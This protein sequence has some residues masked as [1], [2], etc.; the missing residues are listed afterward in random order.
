MDRRSSF[1]AG[2]RAV[3]PATTGIVPFGLIVGAAT[4]AAGLTTVDALGFSVVVFAGASQLA[5][6]DLLTDGAALPVIVVTMLV[7]NLRMVMYSASLAS[8]FEELPLVT[9]L[10]VAYVLTDYAYG[11]SVTRFEDD[12]AVARLWYYLGAALP[13]WVAWQLATVAGAVAG[14]R[15]P[16]SIPLE[17]VVPL[18]FIA[19][20]MP[21]IESRAA[22]GAAVVG[23]GVALAAATLPFN[24]GLM[25]GAVAGILAGVAVDR[26]GPLGG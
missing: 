25:A 23:G 14:A 7:I 19:L 4:V 10:P 24:L 18:V 16:E 2:A 21:A 26:G 1:V 3:L 11:L 6:I 15:V 20:L 8:Y 9:R 5:A 12:G 17:F 22:A 13:I